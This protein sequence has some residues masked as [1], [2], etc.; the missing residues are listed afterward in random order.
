M[1]G[2]VGR[3]YTLSF[4]A[5]DYVACFWDAEL[6][7]YDT[8]YGGIGRSTAEMQTE[9]TFADAGWDF[10]NTWCMIDYPA[11]RC[12]STPGT[13]NYWVMDTEIPSGLRSQAD[14]PF[15]DGIPN[16][17]KYA[18]GLPAMDI[19]TTAD[20]MS[21]EPDDSETFSILYY[22]SK[23]ADDV[24]LQP[25]WAETLFGP[26]SAL[27]ITTD[28]IGEDVDREQWKASIPLDESG[29]IRLQVVSRRWF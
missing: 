10:T 4:G 14:I 11:L 3:P 19:C 2:F 23:T 26:W 24:T 1:G 8:S 16:L 28:M 7:G 5:P 27:D 6:S 15:D 20:L 21:I 13:Y 9:A 18:C 22:K 17:I 29:F 12:F 25:I